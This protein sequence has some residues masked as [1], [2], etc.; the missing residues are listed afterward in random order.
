MNKEDVVHIYNRILL[1]HKKDKIML[2]ATIWMEV[3]IFIFS[4]INQRGKDKYHIILFIYET[5]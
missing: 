5:K 1:S 4:E 2:F 3:G